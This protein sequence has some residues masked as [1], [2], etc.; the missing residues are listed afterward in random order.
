MGEGIN[1][2]LSWSIAM[3]VLIGIVYIFKGVGKIKQAED[4]NENNNQIK[5]SQ[6]KYYAKSYVMT[7]RE[8]ECFKILNEVFSSKW[9]V[10]PQVHLSALL[11]Y[12]VKGQ[13]W[14]AAFRHINGKS[15][16]FVLIGKE[17]FKVICAI[18]LDDST[19]N[20]P[21]RKE[22]D[23]E[24]ERIFN[25]ARIPLARISKFESMTKPELAKAI[26]DVINVK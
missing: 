11:D 12:R 18:E 21:E 13:N 6:Y 16:D 5:K 1:S 24:I 15:V 26:T 14:N 3:I 20:K 17:S 9:F 19:H 8:N 4:S 22:R 10:I 2:A 23:V 7:S 25:Q